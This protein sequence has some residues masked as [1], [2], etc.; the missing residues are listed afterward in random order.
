MPP[1]KP[2]IFYFSLM[3]RYDTIR[4]AILTCAQKPTSVT[5]IYCT[6]PTT[7]KWKTEKVKSKKQ[8][9]SEVSVGLN[10]PGFHVVSPEQKRE[11]MVGRIWRK[12]RIIAWNKRV[13][14]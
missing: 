13:T 7:K 1:T 12:G 4:D 11:A 8:I 14:V 5:L 10:S 6:E 9:C 2:F 3:I